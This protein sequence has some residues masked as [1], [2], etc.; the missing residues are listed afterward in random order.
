MRLGDATE[1]LQE[2]YPPDDSVL[3]EV[4]A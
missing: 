3:M 2:V 1:V 4:N